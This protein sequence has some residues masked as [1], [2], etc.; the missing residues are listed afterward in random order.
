MLTLG[1]THKFTYKI[2]GRVSFSYGKL[3]F[4]TEGATTP[5][6]VGQTS[7]VARKD[8]VKSWSGGLEYQM[9]DW[10]GFKVNYSYT[11]HNSNYFQESYTQSLFTTGISLKF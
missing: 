10:L 8:D 6:G 9:R 5:G 4:N 2:S 1:L 11:D 7:S 3:E